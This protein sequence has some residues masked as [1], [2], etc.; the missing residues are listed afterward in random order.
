MHSA[1]Y[2]HSE[3]FAGTRVA[4]IGSG[5]SGAQILAEVSKVARQ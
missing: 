2:R 1:H 4:I 3:P 5:T